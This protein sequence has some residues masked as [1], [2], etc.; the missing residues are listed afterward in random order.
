M[1]ANSSIAKAEAFRT[2]GGREA[3][4]I[5]GDQNVLVI[6]RISDVA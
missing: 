5:Q 1:A 6:S 2:S 3:S 4:R